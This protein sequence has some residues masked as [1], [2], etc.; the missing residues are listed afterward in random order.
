MS[1]RRREGREHVLGSV[2]GRPA[3]ELVN[4]LE[5][6]A[7]APGEILFLPYLSGERTPH[8]DADA[9]GAFVGL[10][11]SDGPDALVRAV[12]EGVGYAFKDSLRALQVAGSDPEDVFAVGGGARSALWLSILASTLERPLLVPTD[13]DYGAAFGAARLGLCA[14]TGADP[15]S[16]CARPEVRTV[17]DPDPA[18][19]ACYR[20]GFERY[21]ALYPAI[22]EALR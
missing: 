6:G 20:G 13:G 15:M 3:A 16:V 1:R 5:L 18:L 21:R 19:V 8:N 4:G 9:R 22:R 10:G 17:I 12:L 2:V 7:G 14:A 11:R